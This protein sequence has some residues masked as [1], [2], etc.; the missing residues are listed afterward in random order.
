MDKLLLKYEHQDVYFK[1][2]RLINMH[3]IITKN[4]CSHCIVQE[5]L[6]SGPLSHIETRHTHR[7]HHDCI[8]SSC[9]RIRNQKLFTWIH[10]NFLTCSLKFTFCVRSTLQLWRNGS[11]RI[12]LLKKY[13][14]F[15]FFCISVIY[16]WMGINIR[17]ADLKCHFWTSDDIIKGPFASV[18]SNPFMTSSSVTND[19]SVMTA[20]QPWYLFTKSQWCFFFLL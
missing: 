7:R 19:M 10:L 6:C 18:R 13:H 17:E 2:R 11:E 20:W 5:F 3:A 9:Y 8:A 16:L 1:P 14:F 15:T 12:K 4:S